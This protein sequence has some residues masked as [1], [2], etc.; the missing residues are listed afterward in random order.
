VN[1]LR[2]RRPHTGIQPETILRLEILA[3][4]GGRPDVTVE[5]RSHVGTYLTPTGRPVQIGT[6]GA[7]DIAGIVD[8]GLA[9]FLEVK[10]P[11][12]EIRRAGQQSP[13][14]RKYQAMC[15]RRGAHYAVVRSVAEAHAA[16]DA[17]LA[18]ARRHGL[19]G[20]GR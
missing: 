1:A 5:D 19:V 9:V 2:Q 15:E 4:L 7:A 6:E 17:V 20:G 14:Q 18:R 10:V 13:Q 16:V 11:A 3:A 12:S 8:G